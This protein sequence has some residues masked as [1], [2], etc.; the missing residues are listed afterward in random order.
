MFFDIIIFVVG[1]V[2]GFCVAGLG[3]KGNGAAA[4]FFCNLFRLIHKAF[5][6]S[7]PLKF[8]RDPEFGHHQSVGP[9]LRA[10]FYAGKQF[11]VIANNSESFRILPVILV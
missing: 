11:S 6:K 7:L 8:I 10:N 3:L 5:P 1:F 9:F 2:I 4:L